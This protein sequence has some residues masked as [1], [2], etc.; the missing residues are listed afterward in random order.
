MVAGVLSEMRRKRVVPL[1]VVALVVAWVTAIAVMIAKEPAQGAHSKQALA[2]GLQSAIKEQDEEK[3]GRYFSGAAGNEYVKSLLN[4]ME[5]DSV[6]VTLRG[7]HLQ[8]VA[9]KQGCTAFGV[10]QDNDAWLIDPV[11]LLSG[12]R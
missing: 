8:I 11:P 7:D 9:D 12:C 3:A 5:A 10:T 6:T 4:Q 1:V 2:D